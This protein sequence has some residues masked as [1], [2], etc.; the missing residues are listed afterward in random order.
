MDFF[1][2]STL[3][4]LL[5][6]IIMVCISKRYMVRTLCMPLSASVIK[7]NHQKMTQNIYKLFVDEREDDMKVLIETFLPLG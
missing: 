2:N 1:I 4:E 6:E 5:P 7:T 3:Q